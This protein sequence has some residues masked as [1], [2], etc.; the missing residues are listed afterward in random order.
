[1]SS[2]VVD[3][4]QNLG[5]NMNNDLR[6]KLGQPTQLRDK[7]SEVAIL[8]SQR[9]D[10]G[11]QAEYVDV[12]YPA[13]PAMMPKGADSTADVKASASRPVAGGATM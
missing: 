1:V 3:K 13:R 10:I 7:L 12:S 4:F 8:L 6:I 5:L 11:A 2:I 9:P